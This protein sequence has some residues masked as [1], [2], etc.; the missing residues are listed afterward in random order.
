MSKRRKR[1]RPP[2]H[3]AGAFLVLWTA[4]LILGVYG[5]VGW[6]VT[7]GETSVPL[8]LLLA[9]AFGSA[10][11]V[12]AALTGPAMR[13]GGWAAWAALLV[14]CA[15]DA[16]GNV[17]AFNAFDRVA[18][19]EE[20]DKRTEAHTLAL[21]TYTTAQ[22][23]A[24]EAHTGAIKALAALPTAQAVC[25]GYGPVNCERRQKG[26]ADDRQSLTEQRDTAAA[27]LAALV[28]PKAPE[29]ARLL[30]E[31]VTV[32]THALISFALVLGFLGTHHA[33]AKAEAPVQLKGKHKARRKAGPRPQSPAPAVNT[34]TKRDLPDNVRQLPLFG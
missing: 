7:M 13:G 23:T 15:M 3:Y 27:S 16:A 8:A 33:K 6:I 17:N 20:N 24:Q 9:A 32:A 12:A 4:V 25:E 11:A 28:M 10:P 1:Y 2:M 22:A 18:M 29:V 19:Q 34:T 31:W 14:F 26:L 21:A 30:P 5:A